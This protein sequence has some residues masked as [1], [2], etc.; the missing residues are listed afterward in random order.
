MD[1]TQHAELKAVADQIAKAQKDFAATYADDKKTSGEKHEELTKRVAD[2]DAAMKL[3]QSKLDA[4]KSAPAD[5]QPLTDEDRAY[6]S[7]LDGSI[8]DD[9]FKLISSDDAS[10]GGV[11]MGPAARG[12]LMERVREMSPMRE[13]ATVIP[14]SGT[15]RYEHPREQYETDFG[16]QNRKEREPVVETTTGK[17]EV[18]NIFAHERSA[19]PVISNKALRNAR[20]DLAAYIER[21]LRSRFARQEGVDYTVGTGNDQAKGFTKN[22]D[23]IRFKSGN[24]T[25][26]DDHKAL[27]KCMV[28][29]QDE[30]ALGGRWFWNRRT[31]FNLLS[32]ES[33][34][35]VPLWNF[36]T[37][38]EGKPP[39]FL[40][41]AYVNLDAMAAPDISQTGAPYETGDI[42]VAFGD[43]EE[44]YVIVDVE[45]IEVIRDD[46]TRKGFTKFYV[47]RSTGGDVV[48]PR[49]LRLLEIAA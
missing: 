41:H 7:Y 38:R 8:D 31:L 11:V 15:D 25:R 33:N 37:L 18:V 5:S 28:D 10:S 39:E 1:A 21:K 6:K 35:G 13:Y 45:E 14:V 17:F 49:A 46:I 44:A 23:I 30:F 32:F 26:L 22:T 2:I 16:F 9:A 19:E 47:S 4:M 24:A 27:Y 43:M 34:E 12:S 29:L 36:N 3:A 20:F 40:G 48:E 42:A